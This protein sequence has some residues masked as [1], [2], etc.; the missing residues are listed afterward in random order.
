MDVGQDAGIDIRDAARRLGL[1]VAAMRKRVQRGSIPAEKVDGEWR[2]NPFVLKILETTSQDGQDAGKDTSRDTGQDSSPP[3][4]QALLDTLQAEV[5][6]LRHELDTRT[7][8][9]ERKDHIIAGL[10]QRVPLLEAPR[11]T[12]EQ[13]HDGRTGED[14]AP[15]RPWWRF[16]A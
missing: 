10:V 2:I 13:Q 6:R 9:L 8:E 15:R 1:S 7:A 16:W 5:E 12:E 3:L 14:P 4:M 11:P